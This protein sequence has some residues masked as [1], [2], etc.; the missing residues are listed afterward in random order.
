M[1][2]EVKAIYWSE[3]TEIKTARAGMNINAF[4]VHAIL[5]HW[6]QW[7]RH[8]IEQNLKN[9]RKNTLWRLAP[10]HI[11]QCVEKSCVDPQFLLDA[12][13]IDQTADAIY[14]IYLLNRLW[15]IWKYV[16]WIEK[17][18]LRVCSS[19]WTTVIHFAAN[20]VLSRVDLSPCGF[21]I[22]L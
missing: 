17:R 3:Y 16:W 9:K 14:Q 10:F 6:F 20:Q 18:L 2:G 1:A 19:D 13:G 11:G 21:E 7:L 4:Y 15:W 8:L 5:K 12:S 22:E